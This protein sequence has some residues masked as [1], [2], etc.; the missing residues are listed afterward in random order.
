MKN[1]I[2]S[3]IAIFA[4]FAVVNLIYTGEFWDAFFPTVISAILLFVFSVK[5]LVTKSKDC[6]HPI[7]RVLV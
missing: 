2:F 7:L 6:W 5:K 4:L 3:L 1:A